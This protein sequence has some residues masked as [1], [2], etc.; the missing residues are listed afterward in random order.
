MEPPTREEVER[1]R[2]YSEEDLKDMKDDRDYPDLEY[3]IDSQA[4]REMDEPFHILLLGSTFEKPKVTVPYVAGALEYVLDMPFGEGQELSKFAKDQGMSCLGTWP[5][6]ECLT[7]GKQLQQRDIVCRVVPYCEGGQ[8]GWQAKDA[9]GS[10]AN[11]NSD[12]AAYKGHPF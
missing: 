8:R 3:L 11:S 9:S 4:S 7:L 2:S 1:R 6:E 5:R 12:G 10:A